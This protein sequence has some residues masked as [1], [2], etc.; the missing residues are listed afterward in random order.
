[1]RISTR[2][3]T[4]K[5]TIVALS[6]ALLS[7]CA[8]T[9]VVTPES[10]TVPVPLEGCEGQSLQLT[11]H[12]DPDKN[13]APKGTVKGKQVQFKSSDLDR[14]DFSRTF[15]LTLSVIGSEETDCPLRPGT[16]WDAKGIK[17]TP[18]SGESKTYQVPADAFKKRP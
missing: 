5:M 10:F 18:V 1:M 15:D 16:V 8:T 14:F 9:V 4:V 17:L 6:L 2:G 3:N 12:Q 11:V 13:A 7:A